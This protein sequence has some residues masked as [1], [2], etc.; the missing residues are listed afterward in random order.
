[1]IKYNFG[2]EVAN[3]KG[4]IRYRTGPIL[5]NLF[6]DDRLDSSTEREVEDGCDKECSEGENDYK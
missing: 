3:I 4:L 2:Q 6:G 5:V 1:V